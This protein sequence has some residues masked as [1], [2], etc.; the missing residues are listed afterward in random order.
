MSKT[1]AMGLHSPVLKNGA[2]PIVNGV[3]NPS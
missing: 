2:F 3:H 1:V